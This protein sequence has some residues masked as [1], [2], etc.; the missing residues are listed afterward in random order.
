MN[1]FVLKDILCRARKPMNYVF[2]VGGPSTGDGSSRNS[3]NTWV[4]LP[5]CLP[6]MD[7]P[8][9]FVNSAGH[10]IHDYC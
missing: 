3:Q 9:N 4:P 2:V 6:S 5:R 10:S 8:M 7:I 1:L